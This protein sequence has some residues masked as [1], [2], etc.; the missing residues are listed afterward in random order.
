MTQEARLAAYPI[1]THI[2]EKLHAYTRPPTRAGREN[3]Q[4]RDLPDLALLASTRAIEAVGLRSALATT[5][6]FRATHAVAGSVPSPP[7]SW[8]VPYGVIAEERRLAPLPP[9]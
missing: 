9:R 1:E 3:S 5:F 2:A 8:S 4:V 6:A 7:P